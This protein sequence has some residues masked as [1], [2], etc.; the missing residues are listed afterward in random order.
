MKGTTIECQDRIRNVVARI[1]TR[2]QSHYSVYGHG[3]SI[4]ARLTSHLQSEQSTNPKGPSLPILCYELRF[5]VRNVSTH[6]STVR[7][8]LLLQVSVP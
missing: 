2:S 7:R 3:V 1:L 8:L 4:P 6:T 5:N